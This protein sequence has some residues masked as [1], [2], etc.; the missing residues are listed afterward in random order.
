MVVKFILFMLISMLYAWRWHRIEAQEDFKSISAGK[1]DNHIVDV[2]FG[3]GLALGIGFIMTAF[4]P[5]IPWYAMVITL[6]C[7]LSVRFAFFNK[8][9]NELRKKPKGYLSKRGWDNF[10]RK[11][12]YKVRVVLEYSSIPLGVCLSYPILHNIC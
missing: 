1:G 6:I 7:W 10:Y 2:L 4:H 11:I 5:A 9:L 3:A 8:W 12:P